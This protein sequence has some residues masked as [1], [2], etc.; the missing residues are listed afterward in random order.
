MIGSIAF[1]AENMPVVYDCESVHAILN[2]NVC[3]WSVN[4][5]LR[6]IGLQSMAHTD[7]LLLDMKIISITFSATSSHCFLTPGLQ[8]SHN[9]HR[10]ELQTRTYVATREFRKETPEVQ[11]QL[12]LDGI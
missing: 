2:Y 8:D 1:K 10:T 9:S 7:Q 12:W 11:N 3:L 4:T 6:S 5:K